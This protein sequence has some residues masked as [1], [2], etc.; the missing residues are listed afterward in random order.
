MICKSFLYQFHSKPP[1]NFLLSLIDH[2]S[3]G[4]LEVKVDINHI[5]RIP[6]L[7]TKKSPAWMK[8]RQLNGKAVLPYSLKY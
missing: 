4:T 5:L 1:S 7:A 6:Q 3:Y 8:L 2:I